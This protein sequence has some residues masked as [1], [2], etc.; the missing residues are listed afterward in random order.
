MDRTLADHIG[1]LD[2]DL[3]RLD[4]TYKAFEDLPIISRNIDKLIELG[5]DLNR[6]TTGVIL[7]RIKDH[8]NLSGDVFFQSLNEDRMLYL[9]DALNK[10]DLG[11]VDNQTF[12]ES[13]LTDPNDMQFFELVNN[14]LHRFPSDCIV[15]TQAAML[16]FPGVTID[17]IN[18]MLP[19]LYTHKQLSID[20]P[21]P[22]FTGDLLNAAPKFIH[23][24]PNPIMLN[25]TFTGRI[26]NE[27]IRI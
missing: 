21:F 10:L 25:P 20:L 24:Y 13:S 6:K 14:A 17:K 5:L 18:T 26:P 27:I 22:T 15:E 4:A 3:T 19:E 2:P 23:G 9:V 8:S 16:R 11:I 12:L 7:N 1:R